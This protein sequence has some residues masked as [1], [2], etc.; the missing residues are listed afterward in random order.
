[1][2]AA[3]QPATGGCDRFVS[4]A[5]TAIKTNLSLEK[6][7]TNSK[8]SAIPTK[9]SQGLT[10]YIAG[11]RVQ[12]LICYSVE[13][14]SREAP[15]RQNAVQRL[16]HHHLMTSSTRKRAGRGCSKPRTVS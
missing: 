6:E 3:R 10:L 5:K 9:N 16:R 4:T 11:G 2:L 12:R 13:G 8:E 1:M 14:V 7:E 15:A